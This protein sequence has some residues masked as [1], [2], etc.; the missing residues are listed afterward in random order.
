ML[1]EAVTRARDRVPQFFRA[2]Q[3]FGQQHGSGRNDYDERI[4]LTRGIR[5]QPD[6]ADIETSWFAT[7]ELLAAVGGVAEELYAML[8][9]VSPTDVLDRD[10]VAAQAADLVDAGEKLRVGLSR[11][12]GRDDR[13]TVCWLTLGRRDASPSLASAPLSVADT[14]RTTLFGPKESVVLTSATLSTEDNFEYMKS[15]LGFDDARELLLGSP[16]DYQ[17]STLILA[18]SDMPEPDQH[19]YLASLQSAIIEMVAASEGRALVL[20]TSHSGLRAA[21]QGIKRQLEEKEILVLGQGIDGAPKQLL[22]TLKDNHR[23]VLLGASSFWEGVD[24]TG[25]ALSLLIM[26]RLPF[27]VPSDPVYQARSGLFDQPFEQYALPQAILRFKQGFGRLIRRK[28]DRGVVV[29]L[30]RRLR[31]RRY[32]DAFLRS[33]PACELREPPLRDLPAEV[34]SWLAR[35]DP[36]IVT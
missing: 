17:H 1:G 22:A 30:D 11:I 19:G 33:L 32:G 5:V 35:P 27:A 4:S 26:A 3:E 28:T 31:S 24:V 23:T 15:R 20:F 7:E 25:E 8:Q 10:A 36:I 21:Y 6:W 13:E 16:F 9:Q 29:V 2:L 18:P 14:L 34:S 12:I